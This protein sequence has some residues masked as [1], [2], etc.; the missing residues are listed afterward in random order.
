MHV[1][2]FHPTGVKRKVPKKISQ[3]FIFELHMCIAYV[4]GL[5]DYFCTA[6]RKGKFHPI[7]LAPI[8]YNY[9]LIYNVLI[10][11]RVYIHVQN[12]KT[13]CN[14]REKYV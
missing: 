14:E 12:T 11:L 4:H 5:L 1:A 10:P 2:Y 6:A 7:I 13:S 3:L 9:K 8:N